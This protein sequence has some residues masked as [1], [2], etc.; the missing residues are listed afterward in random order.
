MCH[1]KIW[2]ISSFS[3]RS[4][5]ILFREGTERYF[6]CANFNPNDCMLKTVSMA[7]AYQVI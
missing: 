2:L 5:Y 4:T 3:F 7:T 6:G 1:K